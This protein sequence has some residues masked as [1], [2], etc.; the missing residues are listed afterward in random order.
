VGVC[1]TQFM[2]NLF[3]KV[4]NSAHAMVAAL[5]RSI[6]AQPDHSAVR[7]QHKRVVPG[8]ASWRVDSGALDDP[9]R[10]DVCWWTKSIV[11]EVVRGFESWAEPDKRGDKT[12]GTY[13]YACD[14]W[15]LV[16]YGTLVTYGI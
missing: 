11:A 5:V 4:P 13:G 6:F 1:R 12:E 9:R 2:R 3:N 16:I 10:T 8:Q 14:L 15:H 7:D